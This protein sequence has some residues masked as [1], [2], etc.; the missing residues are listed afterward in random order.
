M[1]ISKQ[2]IVP[3]KEV[4]SWKGIPDTLSYSKAHSYLHILTSPEKASEIVDRLIDEYDVQYS[5]VIDILRAAG[6]F[7]A[8]T[9]TERTNKV[10]RDINSKVSLNPPL[11]V[12]DTKER[13]IHIVSG[14]E[15][16]VG[17]YHHN[18]NASV[19]CHVTAWNSPKESS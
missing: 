7:P 16:L 5:N 15:T 10:I 6:N 8:I 12:K 11:I 4:I 13:R 18:P 3:A 19:P 17:V 14:Y 9:F 1:V 2:G